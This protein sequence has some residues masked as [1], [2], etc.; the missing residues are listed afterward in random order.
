LKADVTVFDPAK[1]RDTATFEKPHQ[2]A[3]GFS[4]VIVNGQV[5]FDGHQM[6]SA[7]PGK[8]LYGGRK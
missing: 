2:Y 8:V 4:S 5:V 7:R 1:V 6:T 3:V